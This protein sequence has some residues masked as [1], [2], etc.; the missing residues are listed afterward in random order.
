M[1]TLLIVVAVLAYL[2]F[3]IVQVVG[4]DEREN[5]GIVVFL[6]LPIWIVIGFLFVRSIFHSLIDYL[7]GRRAV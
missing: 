3:G 6:W 5:R 1:K 7:Q 4:I 2:V